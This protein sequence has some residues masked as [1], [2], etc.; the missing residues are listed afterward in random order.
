MIR[1]SVFTWRSPPGLW[2]A[3]VKP[4][5]RER[6]VVADITVREGRE[7]S[8][9]MRERPALFAGGIHPERG[10]GPEGGRLRYCPPVWWFSSTR[11]VSTPWVASVTAA[12]NPV[13]PAPITTTSKVSFILRV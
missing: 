13:G 12:F 7:G 2:R 6:S 4:L 3:R 8:F 11:R 5:W 9:S 10:K 1:R